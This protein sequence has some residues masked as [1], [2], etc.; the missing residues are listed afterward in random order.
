[1]I[2]QSEIVYEPR[3]FWDVQT[4]TPS[5]SPIT[6]ETVVAFDRENF[7]NGTRNP[8]TLSRMCLA[9]VGYT[10][11]EYAG[12]NTPPAGV[13]DF[14]NS[15]A[16]IQKCS[17]LITS[18]RRTQFMRRRQ[19]IPA[20]GA[21]SIDDVSMRNSG[22]DYS[23]GLHNV[24]KWKFDKPMIIPRGGIAEFQLGS[25]VLQPAGFVDSGDDRPRYTVAFQEENGLVGGNARIHT[26][27]MTYYDATGVV[28]QAR[29]FPYQTNIDG[30][31]LTL[32]QNGQVYP[33]AQRFTRDLWRGQQATNAGSTKV[34]GFTVALGQQG[35]DD[36]V[37]NVAIANV[38]G[39]PVAPLSLRTPV[40]IARLTGCG[41]EQNWWRPDIPLALLGYTLGPAHCFELHEPI[42]LH[43]GDTLDVELTVPGAYFLAGDGLQVPDVTITPTYQM[44]ISFLG[45]SAIEG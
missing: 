43:P 36:R 32:G 42:T 22:Q 2:D 29:D 16:V 31:G 34:T 35:Y 33:P 19:R 21:L 39:S 37:Q 6:S 24:V 23:S 26:G 5:S 28:G 15:A 1:M 10:L 18:P 12:L 44:G 8:I 41:S 30:L 7:R 27:L 17:I 14:D 45:H 4:A 20:I 40:G 11:S 25:P 38:P 9:P 13:T 3:A